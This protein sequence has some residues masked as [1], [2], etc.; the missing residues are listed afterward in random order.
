MKKKLLTILFAG[1]SC[2]AQ[3][4]NAGG[5]SALSTQSGSVASYMPVVQC[6]CYAMAA[7]IAVVGV[8]AAYYALQSDNGSGRK[9]IM[10][11]VGSCVTFVAMATALPMFFGY[12]GDGTFTLA[13]ND[14]GSSSGT[15]TPD[16]Y[17]HVDP[18]SVLVGPGGIPTNGIKTD[19]PSLDDPIW[20]PME[21]YR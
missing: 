14:T 8:V 18:N 15:G 3:A 1:S 21:P 11:A 9:V 17:W 16:R 2:L 5:L 7:I 13:M 4:E 12:D 20:R 19:I 6:V 10:G